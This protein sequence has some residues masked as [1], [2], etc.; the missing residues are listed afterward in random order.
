MTLTA[1][2][3]LRH[4]A[5][6]ND[7]YYW[8]ESVYFNF[9]DA[10]NQIGGWIYLWVVPNQPS[11]SG[12]LVSFYHG[13]WPD[14]SI[15]DKAM[16]APGHFLQQENRWIYCFKKDADYLLE[17]DF[18]DADL[19]G[20]HLQR[21]EPLK[22]YRVKFADSEG[23]GFDIDCRF[24][25]PPYDYADGTHPTP[26]WMAANRY[27]R[28][29]RARG[30]L[31]VGD[32]DFAIDCTGD[33]DHSWGQRHHKEFGKNLF[34]MWSFQSPDEDLSISVLKQGVGQQEIALGFVTIDGQVASASEVEAE[35]QYDEHGVQSAIR[36]DVTD[37]LGR[38]VRARMPQMHSYLGSGSRDQFWGFE[39][40]GS[41]EVEGIGSV[42]GLASYFWPAHV[43]PEG[44]RSG[45]WR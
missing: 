39:G 34:K 10:E 31:K 18:D 38:E 13:A 25:M 15:N 35:A 36:L 23:S 3:E 9:N 43:T 8:R 1:A 28:A 24:L 19:F 27:H 26:P 11:P 37:A 33:S 21:N 2:D 4:K 32:H 6:Q 22:S 29:W 12:M 14:L 17:S 40:V 45:K 41:Y 30:T 42:S 5:Q 20:L 44:L 16:A 7:D